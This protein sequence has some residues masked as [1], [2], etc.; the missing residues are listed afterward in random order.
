MSD[1]KDETHL[2]SEFDEIRSTEED[3]RNRKHNH[4]AAKREVTKPIVSTMS[5]IMRSVRKLM[6]EGREEASQEQA[7]TTEFQPMEK[8]SLRASTRNLFQRARTF[9]RGSVGSQ[10]DTDYMEAHAM[11]RQSSNG[12]NKALSPTSPSAANSRYQLMEPEDEGQGGEYRVPSFADTETIQQSLNRVQRRM[13]D[14]WRSLQGA[15]KRLVTSGG[16]SP[17]PASPTKEQTAAGRSKDTFSHL[18]SDK[19]TAAVAS[20]GDSRQEER[21]SRQEAEETSHERRFLRKAAHKMRKQWSR[22]NITMDHQ[23]VD[24]SVQSTDGYVRH[25]SDST[26]VFARRK[27]MVMT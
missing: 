19:D 8:H 2:F 18:L 21:E 1:K 14:S 13:S 17:V 24:A 20:S 22:Q 5:N 15:S 23:V 7:S 12:K 10:I 25:G 27:D 11:E 4:A 26:V 16:G 3:Q 9:S 6:P